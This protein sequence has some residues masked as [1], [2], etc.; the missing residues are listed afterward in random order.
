MVVNL[1]Q[2]LSLSM[3]TFSFSPG[4]SLQLKLFRACL[5]DLRLAFRLVSRL[6]FVS[7]IFLRERLRFHFLHREYSTAKK[8]SDGVQLSLQNSRQMFSGMLIS[9][10]GA[11]SHACALEDVHT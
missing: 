7:V 11:Y 4:L 8:V 2:S 9:S 1:G 10:V 3:L 6:K 5:L